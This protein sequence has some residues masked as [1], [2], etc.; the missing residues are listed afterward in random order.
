LTTD[1]YDANGNTISSTGITRTYDFENH[2]TG[3]GAVGGVVIKNDGDG[4]RVSETIGGVTTKYLVDTL[5]P[6]GYAQVV[7]E[8]VGTAVNRT[9]AYGLNRVSENQLVGG[10]WTP[11]FYG[12]DGHGN[13]R[14][15]TSSAGAVTD[16]FQYDAFGVLIGRTGSTVN[17]YLYTGEQFDST[18]NQYYLRARYYNPPVGRFQTRD[19]IEGRTCSTLSFNPYIYANDDPVNRIDPSG[20]AAAAEYLADYRPLQAVIAS[21]AIYFLAKALAHSLDECG[22]LFVTRPPGTQTKCWYFCPASGLK[23]AFTP[24]ICPVTAP[25]FTLG[26]CD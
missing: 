10:T 7:D 11:S 1:T 22:L 9:Y 2:L 20:K 21:G 26:S 8:V 12:Y 6:T 17:S 14:F 5:N 15:L 24:G 25:E 3:Y 23:C 18:L 4:N 13:V 16:T 19:P